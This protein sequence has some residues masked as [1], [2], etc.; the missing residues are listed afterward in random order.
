ML[1][2]Y[3]KNYISLADDTLKEEDWRHMDKNELCL[4]CCGEKCLSG[5]SDKYHGYLSALMVRYWHL[6]KSNYKQ[7]KGAYSEDEC[8][9]WLV[10]SILG[11]I[12]SESWLNP[13]SSLYNDPLAPDKSIN[14]RMKSHRQGF[15][16]WSNCKKRSGDFTI[17]NSYEHLYDIAGDSAFPRVDGSY[18]DETSLMDASNYIVREFKNK[19]YVSSFILHSILHENVFDLVKDDNGTP[20]FEFS[21]KRLYSSIWNIDEDY[22]REFTNTYK[23]SKDDVDVAADI[24]GNLTRV[25]LY[26]LID[27][28]MEKLS[29]NFRYLKN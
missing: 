28:S 12:K 16:Q 6:I 15:Y 24:C 27:K 13:K 21:K 14:V 10:D 23:I 1:N 8:Y 26:T 2:D 17:N 18:H 19:N 20:H 11:T 7:G 25:R 4:K 3:L 22:K 29:K 9:N 5:E